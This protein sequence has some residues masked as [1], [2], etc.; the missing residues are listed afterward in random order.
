M[1]RKRRRF[2]TLSVVSVLGAVT[3]VAG[4]SFALVVHADNGSDNRAA[5]AHGVAV[6][7][8][9]GAGGAPSGVAIDAQNQQGT[10]GY[11]GLSVQEDS[12][13]LTVAS[14]VAGGPADKAGVKQG[15]VI[16]AVNG[17]SVAS[18]ADLKKA[19]GGKH[20][21][22]TVTL[23]ISR[24]GSAQNLTV[25]LGDAASSGIPANQA[26]GQ[27]NGRLPGLGG[28]GAA[29][30]QGFDHFIS[31]ETKTKDQNGQAHT[32]TVVGGT[33][34]SVSG[35]QVAVTL[36]SGS[37]DQTYTVDSNTRV[38]KGPRNGQSPSQGAGVLAQNDKVLVATRDGSTT[39]TWILAVDANGL[40]GIFGGSSHG[41][42]KGQ[43]GQ[44]G[45]SFGPGGSISITLPGGQTI[46]VPN[47]G[48]NTAPVLPPGSS[49]SNGGRSNRNPFG[50][51]SR[52]PVY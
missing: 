22:D 45:I 9:A 46:T 52:G 3:L 12:G 42:Q 1:I 26:G 6:R 34:K 37:G 51:G 18:Y 7:T 13:K 29:L 23:A 38:I 17:T 16:T 43:G 49:Q 47:P 15:D 4:L 41:G 10:Q 24:G 2:S 48:G 31:V 20:P 28:I 36:N 14:V 50:G 11:L 25:T 30:R 33:V 44:G 19:L 40:G 8:S 35:N 5:S 32:D 27:G 21:G 39:A